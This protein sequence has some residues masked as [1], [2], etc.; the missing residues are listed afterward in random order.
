MLDRFRII[1]VSGRQLG[2]VTGIMLCHRNMQAFLWSFA[3][4]FTTISS[5][6]CLAPTTESL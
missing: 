6:L 5:V 4:P 3:L 2:L 1:Q